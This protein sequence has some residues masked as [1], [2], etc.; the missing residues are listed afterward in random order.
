MENV[1]QEQIDAVES[2]VAQVKETVAKADELLADLK[3]CAGN[4]TKTLI[5]SAVKKQLAGIGI[6]I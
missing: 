6:S 3:N 4:S 2:K 1:T 5:L